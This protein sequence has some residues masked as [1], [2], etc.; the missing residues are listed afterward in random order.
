VKVIRYSLFEKVV[1][2]AFKYLGQISKMTIENQH[3]RHN[4]IFRYSCF[5][6]VVCEAFTYFGQRSEMTDE[7]PSLYY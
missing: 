1:R 7:T 3:I 5:E 4:T 2:K 6:K